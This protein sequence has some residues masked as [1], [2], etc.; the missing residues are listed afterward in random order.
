MDEE[1]RQQYRD[2]IR[3]GG[4]HSI[5]RIIGTHGPLFICEDPLQYLQVLPQGRKKHYDSTHLS[6]EELE[7]L[8]H[9]FAIIFDRVEDKEL[10]DVLYKR[11][12][13][14]CKAYRYL[15]D[16][17]G[18]H[19]RH[20]SQFGAAFIGYK[21]INGHGECLIFFGPLSHLE[22]VA[23][24]RVASSV[25]K[26]AWVL[27]EESREQQHSNNNRNN[28]SDNDDNNNNSSSG[29]G[30]SILKLGKNRRGKQMFRQE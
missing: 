14:S 23:A 29:G 28:E 8:N 20:G 15:T 21:D 4:N 11:H 26:E 22:T 24:V 18:L 2:E 13:L 17:M 10:R 16:V 1:K 27:L 6:I 7:Y 3:V 5:I 25:G 12:T 9:S 19:L 30:F